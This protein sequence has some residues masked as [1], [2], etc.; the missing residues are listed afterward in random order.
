MEFEPT[1]NGFADRPLR[2]SL[3][4][5]AYLL[6]NIFIKEKYGVDNVSQLQSVQNKIKK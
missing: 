3:S 4:I 1:N 2:P 5:T 6:N